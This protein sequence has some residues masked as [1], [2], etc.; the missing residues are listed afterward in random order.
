MKPFNLKVQFL[1]CVVFAASLEAQVSQTAYRAL[2][3][4]DLSRNGLNRVEGVEMYAPRGVFVDTRGAEWRVY[5]SDTLNHR[6]L[7]W[8]NARAYQSGDPPEVILGQ[9]S[10][11]SSGPL[12]IGTKGFNQPTGLA[13]D[14][15]TGDLLVADTG[16]NRI[17]RFTDPFAD[18]TGVEPVAVYGQADFNGRGPGL[19]RA[20]LNQPLGV[21]FDTAG[22]LWVADT[23]N[24]RV[25]RINANTLN[26]TNPGAD[27]V[28]GQAD[29]DSGHAN[30]GAGNP[31]G[32][33]FDTPTG[34]T[35]DPQG[36]LFVSDGNNLRVLRFTAPVLNNASAAAVF[37]QPGPTVK[38]AGQGPNLAIG[39]PAGLA[40]DT[41]TLYVSVPRENRVMIFDSGAL[42][43][44]AGR[45]VIGQPDLN[46]TSANNGSFPRA[47]ARTLSGAS[48]V[49]VDGDG[50]VYIADSFN[51]R[52]VSFPR[53]SKSA[54]KLWGQADFSAN[55]PNQLKATSLSTSYKIVVDYTR[56]PF[57]LFVS[58]TSN[59]RVLGWRDA[60]AF[61][62]GD[63]ADIVIGQP[64]L[65]TGQANI[66][67]RGTRAPSATSLNA[68][69][70]LA[71]DV[72]GN[73]WIADSLNNRVLRFPRPFDQNGRPG[74]DLV[75]GQA[76][77]QSANS[78]G[79]S[80]LS[81]REPAGVAI[82]PDGDIFVADSGN[83]RVLQFPPNVASRGSAIRVLGQPNFSAAAPLTPASAQTLRT[84][85][86]LYVDAASS[87]YVADTG[88]NRVLIYPNIRDAALAGLGAT[89]V[90]GQ[91]TFDGTGAGGD[92]SHLRTP[93]DV[94]VDSSGNIY[95]SDSGNNRVL[96]FPS[97]L[98]LPLTSA[99]ATQV[100][101]QR[102]LNSST[103][104]WNSSDGQATPQS[105]YAP[106]GMFVDRRDTLY[107]GD[108]GNSRVLHFLKSAAIT[109]A[110]NPQ[111][112]VPLARGGMALITG[113]GLTDSGQ[114]APGTPLPSSLAGREVVIGDDLR[115]P[116]ASVQ[117]SQVSLQIP[118]SAPLGSSRMALRVQDTGE[119]IAGGF[120]T[121]SSVAPGLFGGA[122][123]IL[124]EDG[125]AN[126]PTSAALKG[127]VVK[128]YGT[129]Q[130]QVSPAVADGA[131]APDSVSTVAVPTSDGN[132]C[133][134]K[135]PSVCV[136][137][138]NIF[139]EVVFSGLAS[140][141]VGVWEL[142]VRI[143]V[144]AASG[145]SIP[146]RALINGAPSNIVPLAI[147]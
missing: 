119:L 128:I 80:A 73:L 77:F 12:N 42:T 84:P 78:A 16:N 57:A 143:P 103:P 39:G 102:D 36:N 18:T 117:P 37:G 118:G 20:S 85:Q 90:V 95:V 13:V 33:S 55:S 31:S 49:K 50:T 89:L 17:L 6:V 61:R 107:V 38:V 101:G 59:H 2:G 129:G 82:G 106:L 1:A 60:T 137:I 65:S 121:I 146:V 88:N 145:G 5:V 124:N 122:K 83:N 52:V 98:F 100:L 63:P 41:S 66:D 138:G 62:T 74:P 123:G 135:Q 96:Q 10:A 72:G 45:D 67:T 22:N 34:V 93:S 76:D 116:L 56:S 91:D 75:L 134:T 126:S 24:H 30:R 131:A 69:K 4:P 147:R 81:L 47:A 23:G 58:D 35:F 113:S 86:G 25:L 104:N 87:L 3:Q 53:S 28:V 8:R 111:A 130:G 140:G 125:T 112:G 68:P 120:V 15:A 27:V 127:S 14:P 44:A 136:A 97:L 99:A 70:G 19:G 79:V 92:A 40:A 46:S 110:A 11:K 139:G 109:H 64:D 133:L 51:H 43:G 94:G 9:S 114:N 48:D 71:V 132:T 108:A 144:G 141:Q 29:F 26:N 105:L 32:S 115:S 7:G 142:R 54:F 21:A